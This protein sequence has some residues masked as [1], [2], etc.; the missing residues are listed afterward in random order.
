MALQHLINHVTLIVDKSTSMD[1]LRD[2]VVEVFD[3]ALTELKQRSVDVNQETRVSIYLFSADDGYQKDSR[4]PWLEVLAFD[5]DVMRF[6]S[7]KSYYKPNG[8]TALLDAVAKSIEDNRK[9]PELYG[10]HAFLTYVITDG[11]EN[12]SIKTTPAQLTSLFKSLPDNWTTALLVPNQAG[13]NSALRFGFNAGSIS[14]WDATSTKGVESAGTQ[15]TQT[16]N[17]YYAMRSTGVRGTKNLFNLDPSR[18]TKTVLKEVPQQAFDIYPVRQV[19]DIKSYVEA[20]TKEKYRLG[21]TYYQP[22]KAVTLQDYK[23]ILVQDVNTGRVYEG[24]NLR[25]LLGIPDSTVDVNPLK[26]PDYRLF[27][28]SASVNRK[29][30]KD[31]FILVRK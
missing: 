13:V 14:I 15:F 11:Q 20:W 6:T 31:T 5:M 23:K 16:V 12:A 2:K 3:R 19:Q 29:L 4:T 25:Q 18:I 1:G 9:T 30:F 7:L 10:D 8:N 28:Q 27:I 22:T 21:S 26:H 24:E 17:N